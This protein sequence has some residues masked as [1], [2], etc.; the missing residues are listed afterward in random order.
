[1][2]VHC[3]KCR[4]R[5]FTIERVRR[6]TACDM[7]KSRCAN[8]A[9]GL[10]R[11]QN[12]LANYKT[13]KSFGAQFI[14]KSSDLWGA[15]GTQPSNAIWPGDNGNWAEYDRYLTQLASDLKANG[16]TDIKFLIWNEPDLSY[17]WTV[18]AILPGL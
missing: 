1:M 4:A 17:F 14:L 9:L 2:G 10:N 18:G 12:V 5:G 7:S 16:M 6:N 11:F 8:A 13:A 15:D 3:D